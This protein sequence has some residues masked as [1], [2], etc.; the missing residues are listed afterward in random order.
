M[1]LLTLAALGVAISCSETGHLERPNIVLIVIDALR[2][3]HLGCYGYGRPT[4]PVIDGL[5]QDGILFETAVAAAPW[6]KTSFASFL[7]SLYPFQ[8]GVTTWESIMPESVVTVA[9]LLRD[10]GY[11]TMAIVNMLGIT[12]RF[13]VLKG[14]EEVDA[15]AKYKRD[16]AKATS[17]ALEL[18]TKASS[19]FF[20]LIHYFDVHWPYRPPIKYVDIVGKDSGVDAVASRGLVRESDYERPPDDVVSRDQVLYDACI[21]YTDEG[22]GRIVEFL[23]ESGMRDNTIIVITADHGE[24]FWEHGVGSH[25]HSVHDEEIKVPLIINNATLYPKPRRIADQVSLID[26]VPTIIER[27]GVRDGHHREGRDLHRLIAENVS[28]RPEGSFL[29]WDL[30]L[31]ESTLCKSPDAKG[32]RSREWKIMVEPAT[33]LVRLYDLKQD[34][35]ETADVWGRHGA[36]G[37]SLLGLVRSIPGS[38]VNGWRL[39]FTE[40]PEAAVYEANVSL[41]VGQRFTRIDRLV[42]GGEFTLD[43]SDDSASFHLITEPKLQQ[44]LIFDTEPEG[45]R[46]RLDIRVTGPGASDGVYAGAQDTK[47]IGRTFELTT[48]EALGCPDAFDLRRRARQAGAYVWWLPGGRI[49]AAG[50]SSRLTPEEKK[51]LKALGY[52]Q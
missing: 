31:C 19:P 47:P 44:V 10:Q 11:S 6:T 52:I 46:I 51:R 28:R 50:E 34:P 2:P 30:D 32:I 40:G 9:E 29:P 36:M 20:I 38:S 14:F 16:A 33:A 8:H 45:A 5:A 48:Q 27:T 41:T 21:R 1:L 23:E 26:L 43:V 35:G 42:A 18:M 25:G 39:A 37:D 49:I 13:K 4:S 15:A 24:A 12:D 22:V 3:D 7:T 17:D